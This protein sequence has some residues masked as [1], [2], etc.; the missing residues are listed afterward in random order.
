M[1]LIGSAVTVV[2]FGVAQISVWHDA[3]RTF[4]E[5]AFETRLG[6]HRTLTNT[7]ILGGT[8]VT[9]CRERTTVSAVLIGRAIAVIVDI[10]ARFT[11]GREDV[12]F[13][14]SPR[15]RGTNRRT[16]NTSSFTFRD[17]GA[18][19]ALF[20]EAFVDH[21]I[22]VVVFVVTHLGTG[23][24]LVF[25]GSVQSTDTILLTVGT[26]A[27]SGGPIGAV[28]TER[29]CAIFTTRRARRSFLERGGELGI[30]ASFEFIDWL[31]IVVFD[32]FVGTRCC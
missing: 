9:L 25:T 12:A 20:H 30:V 7:C 11:H 21:S 31:A 26:L 4:S 3:S 29:E 6:T 1:T 10:V 24:D 17:F 16:D 18:I 22:A 23:H 28:V 27:R 5:V 14:T 32:C 15:S 2:V 13:A 19:V 8:T